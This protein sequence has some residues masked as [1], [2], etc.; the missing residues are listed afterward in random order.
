MLERVIKIRSG[1]ERE[2]LK[3]AA[4]AFDTSAHNIQLD[5]TGRG[6]F[7]AT[8]LNADAEVSVEISKDGMEA[9]I[10]GYAPSVGK[11]KPLSLE[12][13]TRQLESAGISQPPDPEAAETI[14]KRVAKN[15]DVKGTVIVRGV[16]PEEV[17]DARIEF[18]GD[19]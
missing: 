3:Q 12:T 19:M 10:T 9:V 6:K 8:L 2:A 13:L 16:P 17:S 18:L 4:E 1:N 5:E 14:F 7:Q 15:K 11:G